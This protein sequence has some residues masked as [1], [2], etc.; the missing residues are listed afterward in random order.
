LRESLNTKVDVIGRNRIRDTGYESVAEILQELP[1]VVTR[2]GTQGAG[3][4]GE[5]V[6]GIDSRQVL[7]LFDGQPIIGGKGVKRGVINLDRQSIN[8]LER[9]EVVKGAASAIVEPFVWQRSGV[10]LATLGDDLLWAMAGFLSCYV[11]LLF[12]RHRATAQPG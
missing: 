12:R 11:G 8:T 5:Q 7:S 1:G 2:R 3:A 6:Q 9:I 10:S 4:A